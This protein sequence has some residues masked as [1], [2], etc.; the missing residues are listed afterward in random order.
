MT[1]LFVIGISELPP[2]DAAFAKLHGVGRQMRIDGVVVERCSEDKLRFE[3]GGVTQPYETVWRLLLRA[4]VAQLEGRSD[5]D[6]SWALLKTGIDGSVIER[7]AERLRPRGRI[8]LGLMDARMGNR[9]ARMQPFGPELL[10]VRFDL[11]K[12]S[13]SARR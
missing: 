1:E 7:T 4:L 5:S 10:R 6:A 8:L 11:R 12:L 9:F 3:S 13:A 2:I